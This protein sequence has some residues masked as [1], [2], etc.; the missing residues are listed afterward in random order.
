LT[1]S[2]ERLSADCYALE[3]EVRAYSRIWPATFA[4][5]SGDMLYA[6]SGEAFLDFFMGAGALNYGHNDPRLRDPLIAYLSEDGIVHSLDMMTEAKAAFMQALRDIVLAP[7]KL[8]YAVQFTGPTGTNAVEAALK[9]VR[10]VTGRQTVIAFTRSFH[11]MSLGALAVTANRGGR[12][13]AGVPLDHVLR[14]P[15]EGFGSHRICGLDLLEDLIEAPGSGID[16]PA[17][18]IVETI[19]GEGGINQASVRW[20]QRLARLC[21][22]TGILLIVD[23]IQMGCGR[24]GPF[25]SFEAANI[26]PDVVC[27]AK[28]LSGYGLPMAVT[29][30]RR[31]LDVWL[32]GEHNGTFRGSNPAFVTATAALD[33]YWTTDDLRTSTEEK[34]RLLSAYLDSLCARLPAIG[35]SYRGRG[36]L[37]GLEFDAAGVAKEVSAAAFARGLLVETAGAREEVVKLSP[38]LLITPANLARGMAILE[39]AVEHVIARRSRSRGDTGSE[40]RGQEFRPREHDRRKSA[41]PIP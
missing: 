30:F 3:S 4:R 13:G 12:A 8:D 33:A 35:V 39:D 34:G 2:T 38:S 26:V 6:R 27:L 31:E 32:P 16:L 25:F 1:P 41:S 19:Q 18:V 5:A 21:E 37:W 20:L 36:L 28:S 22:R 10:K 24:T 40:P 14:V 17:A 29:L 9:L 23:D 7:R 11:G 15:Y